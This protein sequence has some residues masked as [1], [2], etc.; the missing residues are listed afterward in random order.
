MCT[1]VLPSR[2]VFGS[3]SGWFV[4]VVKIKIDLENSLRLLL[5]DAWR[6]HV[7]MIWCTAVALHSL[8]ECGLWGP[9]VSSSM[10]SHYARENSV[11]WFKCRPNVSCWEIPLCLSSSSGALYTATFPVSRRWCQRRAPFLSLYV[12]GGGAVGRT[13]VEHN[14]P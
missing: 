1:S 13:V 6:A 11:S 7:H 2:S 8:L 14:S 9:L 4:L 12:S 10:Y 5:R 3:I